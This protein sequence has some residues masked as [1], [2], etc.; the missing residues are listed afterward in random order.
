MADCCQN[1]PQLCQRGLN[2]HTIVLDLPYTEGSSPDHQSVR[3][4]RRLKPQTDRFEFEIEP[5]RFCNNISWK[6]AIGSL[7]NEAFYD[8]P[9]RMIGRVGAIH[10]VDGASTFGH[11]CVFPAAGKIKSQTRCWF[12]V[13]FDLRAFYVRVKILV[14]RRPIDD[15]RNLVVLIVIVER[16]G[17]KRSVTIEQPYFFEPNSNASMNSGLNVTGWTGSEISPVRPLL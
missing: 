9:A 7:R 5:Q 11:L 12:P 17:I 1:T 10:Q 2:R 14:D 8:D 4:D 6:N 3:F 13:E 16:I 15:F